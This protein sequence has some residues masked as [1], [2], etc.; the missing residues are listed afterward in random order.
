MYIYLYVYPPD[1]IGRAVSKLQSAGP[2][3]QIAT[4]GSAVARSCAAG[5]LAALSEAK[6]SSVQ[7]LVDVG[8]AEAAVYLLKV[9]HTRIHSYVSV[10]FNF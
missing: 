6:G 4:S 7:E 10:L 9:V 3:V 1:A 2:L 5:A 8:G